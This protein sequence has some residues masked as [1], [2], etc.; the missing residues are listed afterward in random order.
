MAYRT[1]TY[2]RAVARVKFNDSVYREF[3]REKLLSL[4][5]V[6]DKTSG[7]YTYFAD[8]SRFRRAT[9]HAK[10]DSRIVPDQPNNIR[11]IDRGST[12]PGQPWFLETESGGYT[13]DDILSANM[14][15]QAIKLFG[16]VSTFDAPDLDNEMRN[17]AVTKALNKLADNKANIG[18]NL[19]T[20]KQTLNLIRNPLSTLVNGVKKVHANRA[21]KDFRNMNFFEVNKLLTD[22]L[23]GKALNS[24][25]AGYLQYVYGWKPLMQDIHGLTEIA[26][27]ASQKPL[28]INGRGVSIRSGQSNRFVFGNTSQN[29]STSIGPLSCDSKHVCSLW[30]TIDPNYSGTRSLNQ[31]GLLNPASLGWDI[32]PWSFVIDWVLPIGPVLQA[33]TATAGLD[34]VDGSISN[35]ASAAGPYT[36]RNVFFDGGGFET[37]E[38]KDGS[39]K[40]SYEGYFRQPVSNW[41]RPGVWINPDPFGLGD[42]PW[43]ALALT[44]LALPSL[45]R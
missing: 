6:P 37:L 21:W 42:R 44:I 7:G 3:E 18:E 31:L 20:F 45:R 11:G 15:Y 13:D 10:M 16:M 2:A 1:A 41:P 5:L 32:M 34:F 25:A 22:F 29:T 28:L 23:A 27:K 35:R 12:P 43:K 19:A 40:Y 26:K 39:G 30:A 17:E 9:I 4:T 33:L 8:G 36:N 38:S 14:S 24:A